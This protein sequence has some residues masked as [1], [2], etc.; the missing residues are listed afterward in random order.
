[1]A[2]VTYSATQDFEKQNYILTGDVLGD[3]VTYKT[4]D[5]GKNETQITII[6]RVS[7]LDKPLEGVKFQLMDS[8]KNTIYTDLVT[9]S[10]GKIVIENI[11]PGRYYLEETYTQEGYVRY[12]EIIPVSVGINEKVTIN[13]NNSKE[14][15]LQYSQNNSNITVGKEESN[16]DISKKEENVNVQE[17]DNNI[18]INNKNEN[19]NKQET[20][21]NVNIDNKN[22]NVNEQK[23]NTNVNINNENINTN[24]QDTNT[25]TNISN[26]NENLNIQD[27]N[28]NTNIQNVNTNSQKN[29]IVK[30]PKTG[31]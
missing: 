16:T 18:N 27:T 26:K 5:Y 31:M 24:K 21:S 12:D 6:K 1:M 30:L 20:N 22:Q 2:P 25:N 28:N 13:V 11:L 19:T 3:S 14:E 17:K 23:E 10:E 8:D 15:N 29:N 7:G 4:L 9:D